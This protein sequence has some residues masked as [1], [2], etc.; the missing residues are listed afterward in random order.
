MIDYRKSYLIGLLIGGGVLSDK[1]FTINLPYD[2]W[3]MNP[4]NMN[5]IAVD[6]LTKISN[7][8]QELYQVS[9]TYEIGNKRWTIKPIGVVNLQPLLADLVSLGLPTIGE[10]INSVDLSVAKTK[11]KTIEAESFLSGI[12]DTRASL[13]ESHRRFNDDA[14]VVSIE[15]P[16]S[17]KNFKFVVQL[18]SWLTYQGSV[19]DQVLYNHPCQHAP[20][21]PSYK[22]W[23][24]GFKIRFLVKSFLAKHSFA[25][26]SKAFDVMK[27]EKRQE[28]NEQIACKDRKPQHISPVAIHDDIHSSD[29]PDEVRS[30][31][32][33]HY[34]HVCAAMGCPH[35][36]VKH[37]QEL[38]DN[39]EKYISA[40]P[41]LAKGNEAEMSL[42]YQQIKDEY[43]A[44]TPLLKNNQSVYEIINMDKY[45]KY[46]DLSQGIAYLF[47][48]QLNGKRHTGSQKEIINSVLSQKVLLFFP[49]TL[50][51][52]PILLVNLQNDRAIIVSTV[53]SE[54]NQKIVQE[55]V[56]VDKLKVIV[57]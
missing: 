52:T 17:S 20:S 19:T 11:L 24:K 33:F 40:F 1:T 27:L 48:P 34:H 56:F 14:P 41:R 12:F 53:E 55:K 21:D 26:Q 57:K 49:Q 35:A 3:G 45:R 15:V 4:H 47:S 9:V 16:G 31:L 8:F 29:L 37:I 39:H 30:C 28:K 6:I 44:D 18:C 2:K 54:F 5:T 25:M 42:K 43:F 32:F 7:K 13:T 51:G 38:V 50:E 22:G 36:P 46:I 10:L 23:K